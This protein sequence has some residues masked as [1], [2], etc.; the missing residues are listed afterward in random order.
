MNSVLS[1]R[2]KNKRPVKKKKLSLQ[3][4]RPKKT[5]RINL[6][7]K[8][9]KKRKLRWNVRLKHGVMQNMQPVKPA[10]AAARV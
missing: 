10:L 7:K 6:H 8:P 5:A 9:L 1:V 2:L 4:I 3:L